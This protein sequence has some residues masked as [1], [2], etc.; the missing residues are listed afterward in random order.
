L[1]SNV[2]K[3]GSSLSSGASAMMALLAASGIETSQCCSPCS[4]QDRNQFSTLKRTNSTEVHW[5]FKAFNASNI[6]NLNLKLNIKLISAS[7]DVSPLQAEQTLVTLQNRIHCG[8]S[9]VPK[10]H[11]ILSYVLWNLTI[12]SVLFTCSQSISLSSIS[13]VSNP[14]KSLPNEWL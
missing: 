3:S 12:S 13:T 7:N 10:I 14:L 1:F 2:L 9:Q 5:L 8:Y 6:L 4:S 11:C